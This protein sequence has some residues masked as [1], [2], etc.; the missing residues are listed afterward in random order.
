MAIELGGLVEAK[1]ITEA[2]CGYSMMFLCS[3]RV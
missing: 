2:V 1:L 3:T